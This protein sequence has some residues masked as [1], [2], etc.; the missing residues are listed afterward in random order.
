M[1]IAQSLLPE[2]DQEMASTRRTLERVPDD[3]F[4][5]KP[6]PKS[7]TM[8]WLAGHVANL[9][10]WPTSILGGDSLDI[11]PPGQPAPKSPSIGSRAELLAAFDKNLRE[12]RQAIAAAS[13]QEL[14]KPWSLLSGGKTILTL[15]KVAVLRSFVMNHLIHHRAQLTVYLRLNDV[16]VPALYGPSADEGGF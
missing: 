16:P 13:D 5:W 4:G 7:G 1:A 10:S 6:H 9:P 3:K 14:M 2:F 12:S 8:G 15:P 11:N